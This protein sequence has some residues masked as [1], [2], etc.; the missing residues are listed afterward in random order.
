MYA[1]GE[2]LA[3]VVRCAFSHLLQ[4]LRGRP[5]CVEL[6]SLTD[7]SLLHFAH[8]F[9]GKFFPKIFFFKKYSTIAHA[10]LPSSAQRRPLPPNPDLEP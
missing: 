6:Y 4:A 3:R 9:L 10:G 1:N 5:V 7:K 8:V 2:A